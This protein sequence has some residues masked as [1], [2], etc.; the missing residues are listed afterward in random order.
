MDARLKLR[1][2][3]RALVLQG[4]GGLAVLSGLV[5]TLRQLRT[6]KEG[7]I[8]DR[9]TSAI[10]QLGNTNGKLLVSLGGIYAL[11]RIARDSAGDRP[12][13]VE[14]LAA[15]VRDQSPWPPKA[16]QLPQNAPPAQIPWLRDRLPAVQAALTVL[17]RLPK[18]VDRSARIDLRFTDL[19]RADLTAARLATAT[20]EG[21]HLERARLVRADLSGAQLDGA[22]LTVAD[23]RLAKLPGTW[24]GA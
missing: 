10:S 3:F 20:L 9:F 21:S 13:I 23:L 8:T 22:D 5:L 14:I 6:N 4:V 1:N 11:E 18:Q 7:Q 12:A 24:K 19:R 2:D 16:G 17:G 15:Y